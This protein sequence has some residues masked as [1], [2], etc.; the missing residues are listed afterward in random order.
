MQGAFKDS[1]GFVFR[2]SEITLVGVS[3]FRCARLHLV[4]FTDIFFLFNFLKVFS[5]AVICSILLPLLTTRIS[6]LK[7]CSRGTSNRVAFITLWKSAGIVVKPYNPVLNQ[8]F[9]VDW[10]PTSEKLHCTLDS[11]LSG[12]CPFTYVRSIVENYTAF[13]LRMVCDDICD[14]SSSMIGI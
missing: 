12:C 2:T 8:Y 10:L 3:L 9:P 14:Y 7:T 4:S 5:I 13:C 1:I 11:G 6:S